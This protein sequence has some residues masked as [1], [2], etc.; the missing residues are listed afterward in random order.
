MPHNIEVINNVYKIVPIEV[1][2]VLVVIEQMH[3][4]KVSPKVMIAAIRTNSGSDAKQI[5]DT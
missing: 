3:K 4:A 1:K 5:I 2:S